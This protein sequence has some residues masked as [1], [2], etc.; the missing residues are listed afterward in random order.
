MR[1]AV[2]V[3]ISQLNKHGEELCGD[4]IEL[5][6]NEGSTTIM[7][8]DGLGS[9]VKA[10]ILSRLTTKTAVRMITQGAVLEEVIETLAQTLPKVR[11]HAYSTF[12]ILEIFAGEGAARLVEYDTPEAFVGNGEKLKH[13]NKVKRDIAGKVIYRSTFALEAGD[14]IVLV[15]DGVLHA[16]ANGVWD[17]DWDWQGFSKYF[18][19]Q[20]PAI[21]DASACAQAIAEHCNKLYG[22]RPADDASV[23]VIKVRKPRLLNV[24]IGP[25]NSKDNDFKAVKRLMD[26]DGV[27]IVCGGSTA[28]MVGRILER[29][30]QVDLKS[31]SDR[32]PP[33]GVIDGVDLVT[34]GILTLAYSLELLRTGVTMEQLRANK[35]GSSRLAV[36]LLEADYLNF[37]VGTSV[38]N[39]QQIKG[40]PTRILLKKQVINDLIN[41]LKE[42]GK[43]VSME[44]F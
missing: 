33:I 22:S 31:T 8:S 38:N 43:K 42:K 34:E 25:P 29:Q 6:I 3:G 17:M 20:V 2:D 13:I 30:V 23:A 18:C 4:S 35:D 39:P 28:N 14:W 9:G 7:L 10:N 15:S 5:A 27:K 16:G 12:G 1:I 19:R 11:G 32:I 26:M 21:A 36:L 41:F 40:R 24:L 37:L 44:C